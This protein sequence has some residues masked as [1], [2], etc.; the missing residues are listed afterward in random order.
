MRVLN[1]LSMA[2]QSIAS[3]AE[4]IGILKDEIAIEERIDAMIER[5][6]KRLVQAK[7][8]KQIMVTTSVNGRNRPTEKLPSNQP[9]GSAKIVTKRRNGRRSHSTRGAA[10]TPRADPPSS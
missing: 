10:E 5:A 8:M 3:Q 4:E 6:V 2:L 9:E 7:A 1:Q